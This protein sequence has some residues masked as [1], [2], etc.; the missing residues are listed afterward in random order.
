MAEHDRVRWTLLAPV[1]VAAGLGLTV[2]L[3]VIF[4]PAM[5]FAYRSV[6]GH[7]AMENLDA[8]IAAVVAVLFYGRYRRSRTT[9]DLLV[10]GAFGLLSA[11]GYLL[12]ILPAVDNDPSIVWTSWIPLVVR[13]FAAG[14]IA[15]A[16]ANPHRRVT[17]HGQL[18]ILVLA[19]GAVLL[20]VIVVGLAMGDQLPTPLDPTLSPDASHRPRVVGAG[21]VLAAQ[22]VHGLL[23]GFAAVAFTFYALRSRDDLTR[24]L[25]VGCAFAAFARVNYFL[26]PSLYSQWL[27]TG[28]FLRTAFYLALGIGAV[29]ELLRYWHLQ[30]ESA[31]FAE[32]RRIARDLHD[33][34]VQE[35]GYIRSLARQAARN[36]GDPAAADRIA[37]AAERALAE[38]RQA[39]AALS[40]PLDEP[41]GDA[42]DRAAGEIADR[43][44]VEVHVD[45]DDVRGLDR[46][47]REAIVRVVREAVSNAARHADARRVDVTV[48]AGCV[49]IRDD[50]R[51]FD[52]YASTHGGYGL[53]SMRERAEAVGGSLHVTSRRD[54]GT[55]VRMVWD[56]QPG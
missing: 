43:Y 18:H 4:V 15:L 20:A 24:W 22:A 8:S 1:L 31:V 3:L 27:Y 12:V 19:A 44:D 21:A 7:L 52:P 29:R 30:A 17:D 10:S 26:F 38:A 48:S 35:L 49:E 46:Q 9:R 39:I 25:A 42:I 47:R 40:L 53:V 28:D 55:T 5:H 13:L 2:T 41:L 11:C 45:A 51:G 32:R 6:A 54:A 34:T 37:A 23:Y 36:P 14:L 50:G 16:A 56:D 33:G